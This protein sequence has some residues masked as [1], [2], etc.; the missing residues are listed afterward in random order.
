VSR[1][2]KLSIA[3]VSGLILAQICASLLLPPSYALSVTSD[4]IQFALLLAAVVFLAPNLSRKLNRPPRTRLFWFLMMAGVSFW[5]SYQLLWTYFEVVLRKE[6]PNVFVGDIV[7]F[8]HLVPMMA[9]LALEPETKQDERTSRVGT[10]DFA[11]LLVWWIYLYLYS[12]IPWQYAYPD[13][14]AYSRNFNALYLTEKIAL[15]AGLVALALRSKGAWRKSYTLWF[16][17]CGLYACSS[18]IANWGIATRVYYTGSVYDI[19]LTAS[20]AAISLVGILS[21]GLPLTE[22]RTATR[23][24]HGVWGARW[25]MIAIFSLPI[26]AAW[27]IFDTTNPST[28]RSFRLVLTLGAIMAMGAMVFLRQHLLDRQLMRL[29]RSSEESFENLKRLQVQL[30]QSEKLASLGQLVGGAAHELNNPL[31]AM[32]GYAELLSATELDDDQRVLTD[33]IGVQVRRTKALVASLL[34]FA[35]Q[36]PSEKSRI[37]VNAL[38]QTTIKLLQPQLR[39]HHIEVR[40]ELTPNLPPV[41]GD[42]NQLLQ[43][44]LHVV[45]NALQA[46]EE[47]GKG[48]ITLW[49]GQENATVVIEV[50]DSGPGARE[51]ERV[52][53]PFYTT[54]SIGKGVGLGLSACYGIVQEHGG[55]ISCRNRQEG[56]ATF[57]IELPYPADGNPKRATEAF[58]AAV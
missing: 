20:M 17:A 33:K 42:S 1:H 51:P 16:I 11:L 37:D 38:C 28:V 31:T 14:L 56:G 52:F 10:L 54:K 34:S 44:S 7:L 2:S 45:T 57:R 55:R 19:P 9:A 6:V 13:E 32:L 25:G 21:A 49:T 50:S 22:L 12:V 5:L 40:M 27:S 58:S 30:V 48:I 35:K 46:L 36:A 23:T 4:L 26:F 39:S 8:L 43:V 18:Y 53:D 15:L 29:L 47:N 41:V 24:N 3:G